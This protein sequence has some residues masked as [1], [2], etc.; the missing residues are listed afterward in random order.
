[1]FSRMEPLI[2]ALALAFIV[3]GKADAGVRT[4]YPV[5]VDTTNRTA[6]GSMGSARA[7][8]TGSYIGCWSAA[9]GLVEG[10][11]GDLTVQSGCWARAS[12]TSTAVSCTFPT[13]TNGGAVNAPPPVFAMAR[14]ARITFKWN[15][16]NVCTSLEI[17]IFS[18]NLPKSH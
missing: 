6:S 10:Q 7:G 15:A 18:E 12:S 16:N 11:G 1:M 3:S 5:T 4:S 13:L 17:A 2:C 9:V 14:D 8:A